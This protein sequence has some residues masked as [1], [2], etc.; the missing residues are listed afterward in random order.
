MGKPSKKP[1]VAPQPVGVEYGEVPPGAPRDLGAEIGAW[2]GKV[3]GGVG[4]GM[5][6]RDGVTSSPV[7]GLGSSGGKL[8]GP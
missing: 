7:G 3:R 6:V 5:E 4:V 8:L 2:E 1:E